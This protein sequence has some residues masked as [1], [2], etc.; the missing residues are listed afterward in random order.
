VPP[1]YALIGDNRGIG[2][3][4][5]GIPTSG[6]GTG[7]DASGAAIPPTTNNADDK[8]STSGGDST[9]SAGCSVTPGAR[10]TGSA[11]A[12]FGVLGLFSALRRRRAR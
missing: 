10:T 1:Y 3:D 11:L 9:S 4:S 7:E 12:L 5:L 8:G 6:S 2:H